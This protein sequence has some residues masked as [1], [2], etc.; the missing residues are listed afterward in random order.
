MLF[1]SFSNVDVRFAEL[2][3][4]TWRLQIATKT[5]LITSQV[6]FIN[7]REFAVTA[8]D[9]NFETFVIYIAALEVPIAMP[10]HLLK[11][12]LI[13]NLKLILDVLQ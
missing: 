5:L 4:L 7:K 2:K 3:K 10:I 9:K 11:T 13:P 8:L 12:S 1:L 6:E